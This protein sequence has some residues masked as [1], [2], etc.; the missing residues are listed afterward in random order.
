MRDLYDILGVEPDV[1][2]RAI[3]SAFRKKARA[4][5]PDVNPGDEGAKERFIEIATA[6]EI[7]SDPRRRRLYDE[8]GEESLEEGFDPDRARWRRRHQPRAEPERAEHDSWS[9]RFKRAY[10]SSEGSS[11]GETFEQAFRDF[12]PFAD[13]SHVDDLYESVFREPGEDLHET[14]EVDLMTALAGGLVTLERPA[15]ATLT[16]RIPEGVEDG[17]VLKIEGEGEPSEY[18]GEPGNMWLTIKIQD[19]DLYERD[20]LDLTM[21]LPVTIPEVVLGAQVPVPTPHGQILMTL[22]EGIHGGARLRL[23]QMGVRRGDERGDLYVV[24]QIR[25]PTYIDE[26]L[27]EAARALE[28]GYQE[29]VREDLPD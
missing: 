22:P 18:G 28:R 24:L 8:F 12:N 16:V 9:S 19:H 17:E 21:T 29:D 2:T 3:K 7:L 6:F 14:L 4:H 13:S 10:E 26:Q 15:G 20:D 1:S 11:F 25:A 23:R 5:H 27:R